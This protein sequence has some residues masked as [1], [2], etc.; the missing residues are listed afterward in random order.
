MSS[1]KIPQ[2]RGKNFGG[3][4]LYLVELGELHI[5]L[6]KWRD[7]KGEESKVTLFFV[8]KLKVYLE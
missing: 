6:V 2:E 8:V 7:M 1:F 4:N 3:S 5:D